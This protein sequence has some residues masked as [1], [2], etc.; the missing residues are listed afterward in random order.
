MTTE[1][2]TIV[3]G[4]EIPSTNPVFLTVVGVHVLLGLA[5][6]VTG[7]IAM[8]SEK[9]AG[10]HPR[11]GTIYFW[12]LAGVFLTA[13]GLAAVRWAED[14]H[15]FILGTL[16]FAAACFG[17]EARRR[18]WRHWV[19]LHITGMGSSYVLLLIAFYVD[20]GK[21]L[22][23]WRDLPPVAYWLLPAAV[24]IPLIVRALLWHPL[25]RQ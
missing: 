9:R 25:V 13:T 8:L 11:N 21:S 23:L 24:G 14:Y 15:L 12:C 3:A 1:A 2:T 18:R 20:N 4:I 17:R 6:V 7:A 5:C 19:R 22:P 16:S 10:R